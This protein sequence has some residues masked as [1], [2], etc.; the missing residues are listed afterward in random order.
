MGEDP[1]TVSGRPFLW[2]SKY[3][4]LSLHTQTEVLMGRGDIFT[5]LYK[6]KTCMYSVSG[7][8]VSINNYEYN[9]LV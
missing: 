9:F 8:S 4:L 1:D 5:M 2:Y 7:G 3:F 6:K